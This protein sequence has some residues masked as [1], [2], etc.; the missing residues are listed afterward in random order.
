MSFKLDIYRYNMS[1]FYFY[2]FLLKK[3]WRC[4]IESIWTV[5]TLIQSTMKWKMRLTDNLAT[6]TMLQSVTWLFF[7]F[8]RKSKIWTLKIVINSHSKSLTELPQAEGRPLPTASLPILGSRSL[9]DSSVDSRSFAKSGNFLWLFCLVVAQFCLLLR[10][11][12]LS[13]LSKKERVLVFVT[14]TTDIGK[15]SVYKHC[16]CYLNVQN[17]KQKN[18]SFNQPIALCLAY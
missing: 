6:P 10:A 3:N 9:F 4:Q 16:V 13:T 18:S 7:C 17:V 5:F 8:R 15:I 14:G 11:A 12:R 2:D 1:I